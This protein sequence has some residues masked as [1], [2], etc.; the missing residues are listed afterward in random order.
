[1]ACEP[2]SLAQLAMMA[3]SGSPRPFS[4][5]ELLLKAWAAWVPVDNI[6][7]PGLMLLPPL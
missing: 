1:M 6:R 3:G 7:P 4:V 5:E 2:P